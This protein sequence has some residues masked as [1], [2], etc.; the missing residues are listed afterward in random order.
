MVEII[1]WVLFYLAG[2]VGVI[3]M[4]R[5]EGMDIKDAL[6]S[7]FVE[8]KLAIVVIVLFSWAAIF[9]AAFIHLIRNFVDILLQAIIKIDQLLGSYK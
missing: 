4:C 2:C 5:F 8:E 3:A 9:V 6:H 1:L 7:T